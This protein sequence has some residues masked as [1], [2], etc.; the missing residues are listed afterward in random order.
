MSQTILEHSISALDFPQ[1]DLFL[2]LP[3]FISLQRG[4]ETILKRRSRVLSTAK[5]TGHGEVLL[6]EDF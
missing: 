2:I 3:V 4:K 5:P 1:V 6:G